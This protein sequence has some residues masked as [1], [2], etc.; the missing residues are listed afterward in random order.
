MSRVVCGL[1]GLSLGILTTL[2]LELIGLW[3]QKEGGD[4]PPKWELGK[5]DEQV[6]A[7]ATFSPRVEI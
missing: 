3:H 2:W 4:D 6:N 5:H 7:T 1:G